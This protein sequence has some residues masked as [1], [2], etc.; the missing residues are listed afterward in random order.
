MIA[1]LSGTTHRPEDDHQQQERQADD[2]DDEEREPGR[3]PLADVD[4]RRGLAGHVGRGA[5]A[6]QR[7][8]QHVVAQ[9]V[10][11]RLRGLVLRRGG[12]GWR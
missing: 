2:G 11:E 8:R 1:A 9:V 4:E 6:L 7:L 5:R 10:D 12:R 3:E